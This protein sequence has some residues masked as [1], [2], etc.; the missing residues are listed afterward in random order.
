M[1]GARKVLIVDDNESIRASIAEQLRRSGYAV[2]EADDGVSGLRAALGEKPDAMVLDVVMPGVD[3]FRLC[4]LIRSNGVTSPILMLTE[5]SSI[6]DKKTGFGVGADDY[7][8]KPFDPLEVELRI[9]ALLRRTNEADG[10]GSS[11]ST[12]R[13]DDLVIDLRRHKVTLAERE[14]SLTPIEFQ[15]LKMLAE[16]P[17]VVFSREDILNSIWETSYEGYKRNIDPHVNRLRSKLEVNPRK[18]KYVLT[19]WGFGYKFN[20]TLSS[21]RSQVKEEF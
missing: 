7:L 20:E 1:T 9:G 14:V 3:G 4:E 21:D 8:A 10:N 2:L 13:F 5:R 15:I 19:V 12:L 16:K 11:N 6:D 17:G 18:P